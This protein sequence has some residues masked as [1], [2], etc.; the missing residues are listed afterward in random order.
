LISE[1]ASAGFYKGPTG[2]TYPRIQILQIEN[3][4]EGKETARYPNLDAGAL[5]FKKAAVDQGE[6][7]QVGLFDVPIKAPKKKKKT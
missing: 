7:M 2:A 1:A 5:T 4:I 3:L 6:D